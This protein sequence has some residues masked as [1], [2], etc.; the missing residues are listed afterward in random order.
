MSAKYVTPCVRDYTR[1]SDTVA[2]LL[3]IR[4]LLLK[5]PDVARFIGVEHKLKNDK[6]NILRPDLAGQYDNNTQGILFEVK[7]SLPFDEKLL[8]KELKKLKKYTDPLKNWK[9]SN[10]TVDEHDLILICHI[11]D[12]KR[13]VDSIKQLLTNK[14]YVFMK[15]EGFA[16]W[17]WI[18]NPAKRDRRKEEMR[19]LHCYG[20]TRNKQLENMIQQTGG[21]VITQDVLTYLRF[22]FAFI[23]EKPPIQY[24]IAILI[25]NIFPSFQRIVEKDVY[26]LDIDLIYERTKS[27]FPSWHEFDTET[28]QTKR[29]WIVE[30]IEKM[31]DLGMAEKVVTA[32]DRWLIQIPTLRPRG[33]IQ[34][35]I[36]K[37]LAKA[38]MKRTYRGRRPR[39]G[40]P[41]AFRA[42]PPRGQKRI[43]A[44]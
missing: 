24:T 22:T 33:S 21:I 2:V 40:A 16:I 6:G 34:E 20:K 39:R 17:G 18:L 37:R 29:R 9:T 23:P 3:A 27:F 41:K 4:Q 31:C 38:L 35:A 5:N 13:V 1:Y 30:A 28:I 11:S 25:Q 42:K 26:E 15:N 36:C 8:L 10:G 19:F 32:P 7:W 14:N 44:F 43:D 12:A